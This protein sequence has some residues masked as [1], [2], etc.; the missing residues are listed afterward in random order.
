MHRAHGSEL[1]LPRYYE[2]LPDNLIHAHV[3]LDSLESLEQLEAQAADEKLVETEDD[4]PRDHTRYPPA[5]AQEGA[6]NLVKFCAL[7]HRF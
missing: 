6:F 3:P 2:R 4:A 1:T 7:C 5:V